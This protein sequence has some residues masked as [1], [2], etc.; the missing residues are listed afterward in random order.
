[1]TKRTANSGGTRGRTGA[2]AA[3]GKTEQGATSQS[4][5]LPDL[6][7]PKPVSIEVKSETE[8]QEEKK[9][10]GRPAGTTTKKRETKKAT[11]PVN[12]THFIVLLQTLSGIVASREGMS[13][14]AL[15]QEEATQIA[16]PLANILA[17]NESVGEFTSEY[18]DH[19]ALLIA[20]GTIL[21]P[22]LLI[23]KAT[24]PKET[25]LP[26]TEQKEGVTIER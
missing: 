22:K 24:K 13:M 18:A 10:R 4:V 15:S 21:I 20:C 6:N 12:P 11:P 3:G 9:K 5:G 8:P 17:K 14:F 1:G 2:G 19:I 26:Q 23:Y 7:K 16:T 25:Q